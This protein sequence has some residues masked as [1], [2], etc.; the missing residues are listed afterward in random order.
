VINEFCGEIEILVKF[1][2]HM[3]VKVYDGNKQS[4]IISLTVS[5]FTIFNRGKDGSQLKRITY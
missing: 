3:K 4:Y 2:Q 1:G 5:C